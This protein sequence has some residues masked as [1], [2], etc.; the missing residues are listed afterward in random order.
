MNYL[1]QVWSA[2][3]LKPRE[4]VESVLRY[5]EDWIQLDNVTWF[6][7]STK[8]ASQLSALLAPLMGKTGSWFVAEVHPKNIQGRMA[9]AFWDWINRKI[10]PA[11]T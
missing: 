8:T 5:E 3:G 4:V 9:A 2:P 7:R 1:I 11:S 10:P 6:V